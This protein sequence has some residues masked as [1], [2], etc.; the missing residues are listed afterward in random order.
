MRQNVVALDQP[1]TEKA[2]LGAAFFSL[3][4]EILRFALLVFEGERIR[5]ADAVEHGVDRYSDAPVVQRGFLGRAALEPAPHFR[6]GVR[7]TSTT[8]L[9]VRGGIRTIHVHSA[10]TV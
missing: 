2:A 8:R 6:C 10:S 7:T 4:K 3:T 1:K 5:F 9:L